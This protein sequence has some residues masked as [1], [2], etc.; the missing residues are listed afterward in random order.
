MSAS[1]TPANH[2]GGSFGP[3]EW[4]VDEMY[5]RYQTDP[6]SVDKAWWDFFAD[7]TPPT[8][9]VTA[10][11]GAT[12][13]R[14]GTPPIPKSFGATTTPVVPTATQVVAPTQPPAPKPT[15]VVQAP[16]TST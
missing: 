16:Q 6:A 12:P 10:A 15:Q 7:Y 9:V 5:E 13:P 14:A 3:N 4:L 1:N 8:Q 2:F 11:N